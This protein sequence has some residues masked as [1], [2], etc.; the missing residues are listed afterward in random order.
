MSAETG[1][2]ADRMA[3]AIS[4]RD[5][6]AVTLVLSDGAIHEAGTVGKAL[7]G[8]AR[9]MRA[10]GKSV[11]PGVRLETELVSVDIIDD[12]CRLLLR[13]VERPRRGRQKADSA[14]PAETTEDPE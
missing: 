9:L 13:V 7:V 10:V 12:R 6:M 11:A 1:A 14:A 2:I 3:G 4:R 8:F 5:E